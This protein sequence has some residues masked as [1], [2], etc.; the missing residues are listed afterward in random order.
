MLHMNAFQ[1]CAYETNQFFLFRLVS[2][3]PNISF[4]VRQYS[5]IPKEFQIGNSSGSK[6]FKLNGSSLLK[7]VT[8]L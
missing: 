3:L 4:Y 1:M 6:H 5:E 8:K 2:C 7:M